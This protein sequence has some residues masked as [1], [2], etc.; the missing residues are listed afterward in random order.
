MLLKGEGQK[1]GRGFLCEETTPNPQQTTNNKPTASSVKTIMTPTKKLLEKVIKSGK[2]HN[3]PHISLKAIILSSLKTSMFSFVVSKRVAKHAVRRNLLK[4]RGRSVI[5]SIKP[6]IKNGY[7]G[8][9]FLKSGS[10]ALLFKQLKEEIISL[11]KK[12]KILE[13]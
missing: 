5:S 3:S 1:K 10:S 11:L 8:V 13:N 4:R 2:T 6:N 9:F 12:A 7:I